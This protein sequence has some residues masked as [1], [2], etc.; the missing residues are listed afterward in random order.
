[1]ELIFLPRPILRTP[2]LQQKQNSEILSVTPMQTQLNSMQ[3]DRLLRKK[4]S[5]KYMEAVHHLDAGGHVNNRQKIDEIIA[6]VKNEFPEVELSGIF[7]GIV[8][9]CYL[10]KPYEVHTLDMTGNIITHYKAGEMLPEGMAF[11]CFVLMPAAFLA[12]FSRL[13]H[14]A[15]A[16][17]LKANMPTSAIIKNVDLRFIIAVIF[18]Y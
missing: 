4:R 18:Y 1:M 2:D 9:I 5:K 10:G 15:S 3:I 6:T 12:L 14:C 8:S 13:P 17:V 7:L 11:S 16:G